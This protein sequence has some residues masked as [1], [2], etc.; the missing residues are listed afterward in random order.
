MRVS[1]ELV[2]WNDE[3]GFGFIRDDEG[4]RYFV[5]IS[6]IRRDG[7]RPIEGNRLTFV[8]STGQ[9]GRPVA[10]LAILPRVAP[11]P[12]REESA[13]PRFGSRLLEAAMRGAMATAIVVVAFAS[14]QL[15]LAPTWVLNAYLILGVISMGL[16]AFDKNAAEAGRWR[17][18]ESSLH[19]ADLVGGIAGGLV[20]QVILRH[21]VRK[22]G[23]AAITWGIALLHLGALVALV[24]G[25][26]TLPASLW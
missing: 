1:G 7:G 18:R 24:A 6:D 17:T 3:R 2:Q 26:W 14:T 10:A 8:P 13:S 15:R 4:R 19:L 12:R 11:L 20:A 23:F 5:H 22:Q 16:Y 21:K 9:D 25:L